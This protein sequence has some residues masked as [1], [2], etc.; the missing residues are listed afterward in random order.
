[1]TVGALYITV[2]IPGCG[3]TTF[4][5]S[6]SEDEAWSIVSTDRMR[7]EL[8]GDMS[9]QS[10]NDEVFDALYTKIRTHL[11]AG[12]P[13]A[14]DATNLRQEYREVLKAIAD[15]VDADTYAY[16]FAISNDFDTCQQRNMSR[17]R[18]VPEPIMRRF[19]KTFIEEC[20]ADQLEREGWHVLYPMFG[21]PNDTRPTGGETSTEETDPDQTRS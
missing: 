15:E 18:V 12:W 2:G 3:K 10:R 21:D 6:Q 1:M 5:E 20:D 7:E 16:R 14:V 9:D 4:L 11:S 13:V 8:T 19:H 17:D